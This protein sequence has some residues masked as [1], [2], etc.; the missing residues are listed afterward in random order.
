MSGRL[1]V[2]V[3]LGGRSSERE[4]SLETG[5]NLFY[6]LDPARF[7]AIAIYMDGR[8]RL[9]EIGL[10]LVVQNTTRDIEDRLAAVTFECDEPARARQ[11]HRVVVTGADTHGWTP[12][13][14]DAYVRDRRERRE[15]VERREP[16]G[17]VAVRD[18][19]VGRKD[20]DARNRTG[21]LAS[22]GRF[23]GRRRFR[24]RVVRRGPVPEALGELADARRRLL[25]LEAPHRMRRA[26]RPVERGGHDARSEPRRPLGEHDPPRPRLDWTQTP[27]SVHLR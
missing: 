12:G 14:I 22:R 25:R 11:D 17:D 3:V 2:G 23:R 7:E 26:D 9:W 20:R 19:L 13:E 24:Q 4:I 27:G 18:P 5:R 15:R 6:T 8:G 16:V 1:R 21:R 10:P